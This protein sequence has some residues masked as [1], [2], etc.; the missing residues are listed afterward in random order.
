MNFVSCSMT[1]TETPV[2]RIRKISCRAASVSCGFMPAVGSSSSS[3]SGS[4]ASARAISSRR[5]SPYGRFR[6]TSSSKLD[7]P[8]N[9]SSSWDRCLA[10]RS[11][12]WNRG[13]WNSD[14]S[15]PCFI[16]MCRPTS[17]FSSTV[18]LGNSRM[19]WNVR[20]TPDEVTLAGSCGSSLPR[21]RTVPRVGV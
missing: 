11:P 19:F 2:S 10:S 21:N 17:T 15:G 12:R 1:T 4:V 8:T 9:S 5:W 20:A 7:R 13:P 6:A 18:M 16:R 14:A 3:T